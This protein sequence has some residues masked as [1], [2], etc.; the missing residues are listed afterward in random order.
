M[1]KALLF[2][3]LAALGNALFVY[4]QKKSSIG[5]NAFSYLAGAVFICAACFVVAALAMRTQQEGN[6]S[7]N[8]ITMMIGGV[9]IFMTLIGFYFLYSQYGA[10]Y[11]VLYAVLSIITTTVGVGVFVFGESLN[12]YQI[13]ALVLAISAIILFSFGKILEE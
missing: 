5:N 9:G 6:L 12:R 3:F 7:S 2:A 8:L 13:V 4:G 10:I 11:Y 1:S